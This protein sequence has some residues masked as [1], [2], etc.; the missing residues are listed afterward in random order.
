MTTIYDQT[1]PSIGLQTDVQ[2]L[3]LALIRIGLKQGNSGIELNAEEFNYVIERLN[4]FENLAFKMDDMC[5]AYLDLT[6]NDRSY[7]KYKILEKAT[8]TSHSRKVQPVPDK[9]SNIIHLIRTD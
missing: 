2:N 3:R 8:K 5:N 1:S 4:H 6:E 9:E 7:E